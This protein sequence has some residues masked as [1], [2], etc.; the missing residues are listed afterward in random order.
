[1]ACLEEAPPDVI[2]ATDAAK[3]GVAAVGIDVPRHDEVRSGDEDAIGGA[4]KLAQYSF[5]IPVSWT[6][7]IITIWTA[8]AAIADAA[9]RLGDGK[10]IGYVFARRTKPRRHMADA[11]RT[12]AQ[13]ARNSTPSATAR[14]SFRT[15]SPTSGP[16]GRTSRARPQRSGRK[17]EQVRGGVILVPESYSR[18]GNGS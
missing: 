14:G 9:N 3:G 7:L 13:R 1:M 8:W 18:N 15:S 2:T 16:M 11:P 6:L 17:S 4:G 5:L 12:E 10:I